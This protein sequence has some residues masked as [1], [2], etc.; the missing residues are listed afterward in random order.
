MRD[1]VEMSIKSNTIGLKYGSIK[2]AIGLEQ[3][4]DRIS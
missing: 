1:V 4:I 3:D 2:L